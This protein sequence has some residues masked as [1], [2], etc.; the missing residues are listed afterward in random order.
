MEIAQTGRQPKR[1]GKKIL[2]VCTTDIMIRSFLI[3]HIEALLE[4]G[5]EVECAC[6]ATDFVE[7]LRDRF[8]L[9]VYELGF[10][11][12]PFSL[13]NLTGLMELKRLIDTRGYDILYCHEP[14]GGALGRIAGKLCKKKVLYIA[15]GFHF[16][17]GAPLMNWLVFF[18]VERALARYTD[19]LIT[20]NRE[21]YTRAGK[22]R[23]KK[24][25][26]IPG[27]GVDTQKAV[28]TSCRTEMR[29]ALGI[30]QNAFAVVSVG[31]LIKRKNHESA[32][33]AIA[34]LKRQDVFYVVCGRGAL[35]A[36]LK[37]LAKDLKIEN[38]VIF[39][40]FRKDIP[41]ILAAC[42]LFLF[43]SLQEGL[44]VALMEAMAAGLPVVCSQIRGNTDL[45]V[46]ERGGLLVRPKDAAGYADAIK[47]LADNKDQRD[48][49]G[50]ANM[51]AIRQYDIKNVRQRLKDI[52]NQE[53][54]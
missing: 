25:L 21:D 1:S 24:T 31:E 54:V 15:H 9:A 36:D 33:L 49:M 52:F 28:D 45:I 14:V 30:P 37:S 51:E 22:L 7:E 35:E 39:L 42:D 43:P 53:F 13:E 48:A 32:V 41:R 46:P 38:R 27:I 12:F 44:P 29:E 16:Y 50:R 6:A 19:V 10:E 3:P 23:A 11:R 26:Y 5:N 17:K 40:G 4:E 34:Q 8:G 20:I 18:P 47:R 2:V